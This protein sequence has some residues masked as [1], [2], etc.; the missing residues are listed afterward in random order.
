[1]L[2]R[3]NEKVRA[4]FPWRVGGQD[5]RDWRFQSLKKA[6]EKKVTKWDKGNCGSGSRESGDISQS[7]AGN[8]KGARSNMGTVRQKLP[9]PIHV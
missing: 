8:W 2:I 1:M 7:D 5:E 6:L 3:A 4:L 9:Q